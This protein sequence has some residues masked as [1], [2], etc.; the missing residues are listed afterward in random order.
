MSPP[1]RREIDVPPYRVMVIAR[2]EYRAASISEIE[3][4]LARPTITRLDA[5]PVFLLTSN[6]QCAMANSERVMQSTL[7][8]RTRTVSW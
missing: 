7:D 1:S 4:Y 3:G 5:S 8:S 6:Q 2:P